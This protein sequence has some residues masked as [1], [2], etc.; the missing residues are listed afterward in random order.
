VN[1]D[2]SPRE[3]LQSLISCHAQ[4]CKEL[5]AF[6]TYGLSTLNHM[7]PVQALHQVKGEC[8]NEL[9]PYEDLLTAIIHVHAHEQGIRNHDRLATCDRGHPACALVICDPVTD[10]PITPEEFSPCTVQSEQLLAL[11]LIDPKKVRDRT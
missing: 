6:R 4:A 7:D 9:I 8:E 10:Q 1:Q 2:P 11:Y 5:I 3:M